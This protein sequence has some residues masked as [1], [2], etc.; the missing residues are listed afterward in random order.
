MLSKD[1][2][3]LKVAVCKRKETDPILNPHLAHDLADLDALRRQG[4]PI[5]IANA[6]SLYYDGSENCSFDLPL[7]MQ[8]GVDIN[9]MWERSQS[10][11]KAMSK[12]GAKSVDINP[13]K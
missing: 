11:H 6:E 5:S 10:V 12:L 8:R 3:P 4:K 1:I 2:K 7:D 9:M 13:S